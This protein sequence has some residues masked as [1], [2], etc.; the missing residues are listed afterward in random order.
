MRNFE[1]ELKEQGWTFTGMKANFGRNLIAWQYQ[2]KN[3]EVR[4]FKP[5]TNVEVE[6]K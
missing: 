6:L 3:G 1:K 5:F 4:Y 2:N